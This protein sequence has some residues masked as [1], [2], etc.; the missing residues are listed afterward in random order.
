[1]EVDLFLI[2]VNDTMALS[3]LAFALHKLGNE[4]VIALDGSSLGGSSSTGAPG[5]PIMGIFLLI[6]ADAFVQ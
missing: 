3:A 6:S 1:M 5:C 2:S 4:P